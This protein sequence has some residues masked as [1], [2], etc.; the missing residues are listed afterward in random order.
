MTLTPWMRLSVAC[1]LLLW[2]AHSL[3]EWP[4]RIGLLA[5]A[6]LWT[7]WAAVGAMGGDDGDS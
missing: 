7:A 1:V 4:L 3:G 6:G 2:F 5:I